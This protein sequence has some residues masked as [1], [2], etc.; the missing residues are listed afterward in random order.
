MDD[1][2]RFLYE[3]DESIALSGEV[4][5]HQR[6]DAAGAERQA[7]GVMSPV[8]A[9]LLLA[10]LLVGAGI[11]LALSLPKDTATEPPAAG[12][13]PVATPTAS[14]ASAPSAEMPTEA[15]II[16]R[17]KQLQAL[18][19]KAYRRADSSL[20]PQIYTP[21]SPARSVVRGELR[22]LRLER[23][24]S[25]TKSDTRSLEVT[26]VSQSEIRLT[27]V[28]V[29]QPLF[30]RDGRDVTLRPRRQRLTVDWV[31]RRHEGRWFFFRSTITAARNLGR[32][33]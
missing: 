2:S 28:V 23:V 21:D 15:E 8:R 32:K 9:F 1:P 27:E 19:A 22:N 18:H 6:V 26:S 17:F 4:L 7:K 5:M 10:V 13:G 20:I 11:A 24:S 31:L 29:E 30:L 12:P 33:P 3:H 16:E 14:G 25:R